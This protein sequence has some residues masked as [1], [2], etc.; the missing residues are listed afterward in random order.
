MAKVCMRYTNKLLI[1]VALMCLFSL[2]CMYSKENTDI[3]SLEIVR[4]DSL[5]DKCVILRSNEKLEE[6]KRSAQNIPIP[7]FNYGRHRRPNEN[8]YAVM[9]LM[10]ADS[11]R[12]EYEYFFIRDISDEDAKTIEEWVRLNCDILDEGLLDDAKKICRMERTGA[13]FNSTNGVFMLDNDLISR[14]LW[15]KSVVEKKRQNGGIEN[16]GIGDCLQRLRNYFGENN[17]NFLSVKSI[18]LGSSDKVFIDALNFLNGGD[19]V[20]C[21]DFVLDRQQLE[22]IKDWIWANE[23]NISDEMFYEIQSFMYLKSLLSNEVDDADYNRLYDKYR[24]IYI[25]KME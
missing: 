17:D 20:C 19:F 10:K 2:E 4:S 24:D 5:Q 7:I 6:L 12:L 3:E 11:Y 18:Y 13:Y 9:K 21:E 22:K 25:I 23:G 1:A 15:R 14:V 8:E 16:H